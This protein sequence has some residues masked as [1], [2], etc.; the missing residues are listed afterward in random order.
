MAH[1]FVGIGKEVLDQAQILQLIKELR[2]K[3]LE[4]KKN[5][6]DEAEGVLKSMIAKI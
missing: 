1:G 6:F 5:K 2:W 3:T 4:Q